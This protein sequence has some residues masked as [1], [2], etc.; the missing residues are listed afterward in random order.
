MILSLAN[1]RFESARCHELRDQN[2]AF[3]PFA[4]SLPG[5]VEAHDVGMLETLQHPGLLFEALAL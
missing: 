3:L 2:D 5:V 1:S 4:G